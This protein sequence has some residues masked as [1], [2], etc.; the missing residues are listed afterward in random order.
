MLAPLLGVEEEKKQTEHLV[1]MAKLQFALFYL[2][3]CPFLTPLRYVKHETSSFVRI[4]CLSFVFFSL[5]SAD[6]RLLERHFEEV[7]FS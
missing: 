2:R 4:H 3:S 1:S 7:D 5:L 6:S